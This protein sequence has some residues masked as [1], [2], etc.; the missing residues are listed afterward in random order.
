MFHGTNDFLPFEHVTNIHDQ[1]DANGTP[2]RFLRAYKRGH[3]FGTVSG[4]P[5]GVPTGARAQNYAFQLQL[6]WFRE[7]LGLPAPR[8]MLTL[9]GLAPLPIGFPVR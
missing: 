2:T 6:S 9:P 5:Q 7:H 3:G 1:V 8:F 4:D